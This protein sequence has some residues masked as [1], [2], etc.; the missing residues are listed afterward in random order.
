MI[1][2]QNARERKKIFP[3]QSRVKGAQADEDYDI[4]LS[5]LLY[6]GWKSAESP[7]LAHTLDKIGCGL[8]QWPKDMACLPD[9]DR[10]FDPSKVDIAI[11]D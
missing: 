9:R 11:A 3:I 10:M 5:P 2:S 8:R 4:W 1:W 7:R 6:F